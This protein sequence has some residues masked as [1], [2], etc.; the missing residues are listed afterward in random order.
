[1][2]LYDTPDMRRP[3]AAGAGLLAGAPVI[4][5]ALALLAFGGAQMSA[6]F[7]FGMLALT[8]LC[9]AAGA[10][11]GWRIGTWARDPLMHM[12]QFIHDM[13]AT[14]DGASKEMPFIACK[15]PLGDI[16]RGT[17]TSKEWMQ[18]RARR[19]V[20]NAERAR[21]DQETQARLDEERRI[22]EQAKARHDE[23]RRQAEEA[24]AARAREQAAVV[25][26]LASGLALLAEGDLEFRI[27]QD[28]P[29]SYQKLKDDF[30]GA[31]D[32][33]HGVMRS[34]A[35]SA[36][37]VRA[38][39]NEISQSADDLSRRTEHQAA[40]LEEAAAALDQITMTVRRTADGAKEVSTAVLEAKTDAERSGQVVR[41]AVSAMSEISRSAQEISQIISVIDEIAFQTNL[42][43]LNA[44]VEAARA[45]EAGR[46]FAVVASEVRAL[47][48]RSAGAAKEIKALISTSTH[49]VNSGVQLVGNAGQAL[50]RIL[51]KVGDISALTMEIATSA[52]EQAVGL[53]EVNASIGQMDHVTQ[54][55]AAMVEEATAASYALVSEAQQLNDL[56]A[57]F[58]IGEMPEVAP[59]PAP[60]PRPTPR[61]RR[62]APAPRV[63]GNLALAAR[64]E[65]DEDESWEEF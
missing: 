37:G 10:G 39:A 23:E 56:I 50:D 52:K 60:R 31:M 35:T 58:D 48:Q 6:P 64:A 26:S 46:G 57:K 5:T 27:R 34:I 25:E 9:A 45:G 29:A 17:N 18:E 2:N 65:L 41:D 62:A 24:A 47:A 4:V 13:Y 55:N 21:K 59:R 54:Q 40:S 14:E 43:A 63:S 44:G 28:F 51:T 53:H 7:V 22:A 33:L 38:G 42:L 30:N 16:A 12:A 20:E 61:A 49:Q 11:A 8:M 19:R 15:G 32:K 1:M 36:L 3:F